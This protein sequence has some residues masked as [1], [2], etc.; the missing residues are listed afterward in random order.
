MT[1]GAVRRIRPAA[2]ALAAA[3]LFAF[4]A[5]PG[6]AASPGGSQP[7]PPPAPLTNEDIVRLVVN[8]TAEPVILREIDARPPAF[9]LDPGVVVELERVGVSRTIIEAMKRRQGGVP[10]PKPPTPPPGERSGAPAAAPPA[11][12]PAASLEIAFVPGPKGKPAEVF[13]I[14]TL[15]KGAPRPD[16]SEIGLVS[17]LALAV[18]CTTTDHVPDH[19]DTLTPIEGG[20]RHEVVFFRPGSRTIRQHGFDLLALDRSPTGPIP[21]TPGRH[22]LV[23][24]LAGKAGSGAWRLLASTTLRL[25]AVAGRTH[26]LL[27]DARSGLPGSRMT[28]YRAEQVWTVRE[29]G[30]EGEEGATAAPPA[31]A[32]GAPAQPAPP[33]RDPPRDA[34]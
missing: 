34:T 25:D 31:T 12:E 9:D 20:P 33:P 32:P 11:G 5:A 30:S 18:L 10:R 13:A 29:E 14:A 8:G 23:V 2:L 3:A 6:A 24:A 21:L 7:A 27:L 17:E 16:N 19:W 22:A 4:L 1:P 26:R 15:P 28:G